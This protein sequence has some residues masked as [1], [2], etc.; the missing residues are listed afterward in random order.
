MIDCAYDKD[1]IKSAINKHLSGNHYKSS[2]IYGRGDSGKK[3]A[4]ILANIDLTF[5]KTMTY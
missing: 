5:Q 4:N 3:I 1:E 2:Y